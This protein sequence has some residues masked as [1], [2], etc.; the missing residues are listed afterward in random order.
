M[1]ITL[2]Q[3]PQHLQKQT[4]PFYTLL[5]NELLLVL[6]A[7][8]LIRI[9]ARQQGYTERKLFTVD[10]HF[11]WS[12]LLNSG[13][14]LSLFG[15][16]KILDIRIPSGK[17]GK[18]G[19]KAIEAYCNALPPDTVT[20]I[21]LPWIDKQGRATKWF[22]ILENT[23]VLIPVYTIEHDQLPTWIGHR[24][25]R[26]NQKTDSA[27]LQFLADQ[28]EGNLLAAHQEIQKLALL[29]PSGN[30]TFD[31]VKDVVL[32]VAR[33]DVYQLSDAM[34]SANA[35]RYTRIL[36][37]LQ[38]EG[39]APLLILATLTEQIRQLIIIRTGLDSGHSP[40]QL[41]QTARIWGDRQ[42][43]TISAARRISLQSLTQGLSAAAI[44]DRIIKGVAKGDVWDELLQ[45]G[46]RFTQPSNHSQLS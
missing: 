42:K 38:G 43:S 19:G 5:G 17:P 30:L 28:V 34:L 3:L 2:E 12:D 22:K 18:E 32:N 45:L 23:S 46:L 31:Q 27:T 1:R 41:L 15:D 8:D 4:A 24:L 25:A 40:A 6:E 11:D 37:G 7:A 26:Q 14:N 35:T 29:Y 33:Y 10:Q 44:I 21:T 16:R 39:T 20:L 36:T 9:H 13:S